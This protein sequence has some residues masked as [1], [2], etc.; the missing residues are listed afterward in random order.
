MGRHGT[1]RRT[2]STRGQI[3]FPS[4]T[5]LTA[6]RFVTK[7][8]NRPRQTLI[9]DLAPRRTH[10]LRKTGGG[11]KLSV[12][13]DENPAT[14]ARREII[15]FLRG[16][17]G[18]SWKIFSFPWTNV[19]AR[20]RFCTVALPRSNGPGNFSDTLGTLNT[21]RNPATLQHSLIQ[22][23]LN[24][25]TTLL[26]AIPHPFFGRSPTRPSPCETQRVNPPAPP[27]PPIPLWSRRRR[28][29]RCNPTIQ[30]YCWTSGSLF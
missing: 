24:P 17:R 3:Q 16:A 6:D 10:P 15:S 30:R 22:L 25:E 18:A 8:I 26:P 29:C 13:G 27:A 21:V 9:P 28:R 7:R 14:L 23:S 12:E 1:P 19:F 2:N 20:A 11:R 4:A 5:E